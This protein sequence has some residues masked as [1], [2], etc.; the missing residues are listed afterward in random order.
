MSHSTLKTTAPY[1]QGGFSFTLEH[2]RYTYTERKI[3]V[4]INK[5]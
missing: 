5:L 1:T 3:T 4:E 2:K